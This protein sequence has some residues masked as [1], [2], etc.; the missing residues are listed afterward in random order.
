MEVGSQLDIGAPWSSLVGDELKLVAKHI[1]KTQTF[2]FN[3]DYDLMPIYRLTTS[4]TGKVY[5][6]G[7][8]LR[9]KHSFLYTSFSTWITVVL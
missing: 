6:N 7:F 4:Y 1:W 3:Q 2:L 8:Q 5:R 9:L